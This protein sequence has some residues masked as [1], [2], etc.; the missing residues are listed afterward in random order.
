MANN[1]RR[2]ELTFRVAGLPAGATENDAASIIGQ[3]CDHS[4]FACH[5]T[6]HSL[7]YDPYCLGQHME[8]VATVTFG[9]LPP[10][11]A[12]GRNPVIEEHADFRG[13]SIWTSLT[14]DSDFLG[15]TPLNEVY[16]PQ[17]EIIE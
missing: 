3:L 7:G 16:L 6:V 17:E 14:F 10:R 2:R 1:D 12:N 11:V 9:S 5:P 15:F 13:E 8:M 4:D